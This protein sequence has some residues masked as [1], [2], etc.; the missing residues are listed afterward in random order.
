MIMDEEAV[1][2]AEN[3]QGPL[4]R[5]I[6]RSFLPTRDYNHTEEDL[7]DGI[8]FVLGHSE[9]KGKLC[10]LQTEPGMK[11]QTLLVANIQNSCIW[12]TAPELFVGFIRSRFSNALSYEPTNIANIIHDVKDKFSKM[13]GM[14]ARGETD[15][16]VGKFFGS[17]VKSSVHPERY[18]EREWQFFKQDDSKTPD[19]GVMLLRKNK[20]G[21][22]YFTVLYNEIVN[23]DFRLKKSDLYKKLYKKPYGLR[24]ILLVD[25]GCTTTSGVN[26]ENVQTLHNGHFG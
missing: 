12:F 15:P 8:V 20:K 25:F 10:H 16:N 4:P 17:K 24:N 7:Y 14:I 5:N 2:A 21:K 19:G 18:C 23:G 13:K 3:K 9:F 11:Q 1:Q 6:T 26:E 22:S